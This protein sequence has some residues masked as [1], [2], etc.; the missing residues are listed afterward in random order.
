MREPSLKFR[1]RK[2]LNIALPSGFSS[3]LDI[4]NIAIGMIFIGRLSSEHI[5]AVGVGLNFVMMFYVIANI[6]FIGTNSLTSRRYGKRD[7]DG[8]NTVLG[9]MFLSSIVLSLPLFLVAN[10]I[11]EPFLHWMKLSD[12][13]FE[14]GKQFLFV[15]NFTALGLLA[16][17][18]LISALSAIGDTKTPFIVKIFLTALNIFLSYGLIFGNFGLP[19]LE[20]VGAGISNIITLL[21]EIVALFLVIFMKKRVISFKFEIDFG[22]LKNALSIGIPSGMERAF[23]IGSLILITKFLASYGSVDVAG[24]QIGSRIEA[25]IFMPG[26]GFMVASMVLMGQNLVANREA[27]AIKFVYTTL[28]IAIIL[29]GGMGILMAL[30]PDILSSI[31]T[32]DRGVI[33]ISSYYLIAVGLSQMALITIFVLDGALRGAGATKISLLINTLSIWI[34]RVLPM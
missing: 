18:V 25:F 32:S 28:V 7:M 21:C 34:L 2:I 12:R 31:F 20:I 14:L 16:R 26:F 19:R 22:I 15:L 5:V 17:T 13:A 24:F 1:V 6:F 23:T 30:I 11:Y 33:Q 9:T 4:L 29:M 3:L 8:A 27:L 10:S